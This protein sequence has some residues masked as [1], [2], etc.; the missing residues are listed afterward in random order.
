MISSSSRFATTFFICAVWR[1]A[2]APFRTLALSLQDD[3]MKK[4]DADEGQSAS[5]LIS[6]RIA[7][8][9]D[10]R[11]KALS[12]VRTLVTSALRACAPRSTTA[13]AARWRPSAAVRPRRA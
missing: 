2:L 4:S 10:W 13:W 5:A 12:R 7:D 6:K 9:G 8:L 11:G 3:A 1:P